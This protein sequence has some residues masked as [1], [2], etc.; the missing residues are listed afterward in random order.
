MGSVFKI[1]ALIVYV[2][3]GLWGLIVCLGIVSSKAGTLA[4]II[5]FF[6]LPITLYIAPW[7]VGFVESNWFPVLLVYGS[8]IAAAI[9]YGIGA[10]IDGD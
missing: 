9:L 1:P 5:A 4:A 2:V 7:Y 10:L 6:V 3:G 8:G